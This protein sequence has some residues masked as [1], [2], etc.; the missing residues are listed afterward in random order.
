M[1]VIIWIVTM[2]LSLL[3][4]SIWVK[5]PKTPPQKNKRGVLFWKHWLNSGDKE[6]ANMK[7]IYPKAGLW[8]LDHR[9]PGWLFHPLMQ[10]QTSALWYNRAPAPF[11]PPALHCARC[12]PARIQHLGEIRRNYVF[13]CCQMQIPNHTRA[14]LFSICSN[15]NFCK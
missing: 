13:H 7:I 12:C 8:V 2:S 4:A 1:S 9:G 10:S 3:F 11:S 14:Y 15:V 6:N 5:I